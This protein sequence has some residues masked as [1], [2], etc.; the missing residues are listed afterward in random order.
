MDV[1]CNE[2]AVCGLLSV[3]SEVGHRFRQHSGALVGID[4]RKQGLLGCGGLKTGTVRLGFELGVHLFS[5][6]AHHPER[7]RAVKENVTMIRLLNVC[8]AIFKRGRECTKFM[9]LFS[10]EAVKIRI[11]F[12]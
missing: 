7:I 9:R 4:A 10:H 8:L 12:H 6:I 3:L 5:F 11:K 1:C 2:S